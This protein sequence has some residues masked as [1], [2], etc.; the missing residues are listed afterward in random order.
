MRFGL[1]LTP[2][3]NPNQ[4]G[5][6]IR[7]G[8]S[9]L[10]LLPSAPSLRS[11]ERMQLEVTLLGDGGEAL[12]R[13]PNPNPSPN[14]SPIAHPKPKPNPNPSRTPYPTQALLRSPLSSRSM[15]LSHGRVSTELDVGWTRLLSVPEG[16]ELWTKL[17][18]ALASADED[19][20][21]HLALVLVGIGSATG[22]RALGRCAHSLRAQLLSGVD[23]VGAPLDVMD[24]P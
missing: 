1:G 15:L 10:Q 21:P 22:R 18:A 7:L 4:E 5:G 2:I 12:L 11:V 19:G 9:G 13:A 3:L 17:R 16:G 23:A 6:V 8:V 24:T 20:P 14:P